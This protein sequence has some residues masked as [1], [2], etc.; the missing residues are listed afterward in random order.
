[1]NAIAT[2]LLTLRPVFTPRA[3]EVVW[4][5]YVASTV[6][7]LAPLVFLNSA[8]NSPSQWLFLLMGALRS[9]MT[10]VLVRLLL[11][12]AIRIVAFREPEETKSGTT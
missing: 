5:L 8:L 9:I 7:E 12:V 2:F 4:F 6:I 1:M 3:L 10:L 11:E